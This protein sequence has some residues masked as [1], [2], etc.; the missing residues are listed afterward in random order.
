MCL[1]KRIIEHHIDLSTDPATSNF[2]SISPPLL[3]TL[4]L[5]LEFSLSPSQSV[6]PE[7]NEPARS[8]LVL[9]GRRLLEQVQERLLEEGDY[10]LWEIKMLENIRT[11]V[12]VLITKSQ[13]TA[14]QKTE[15]A[16]LVDKLTISL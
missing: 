10:N 2:E 11:S 12:C 1:P 6:A 14:E 16:A 3:Q 13:Q 7:H 5:S 4:N 8:M 15:V 9:K